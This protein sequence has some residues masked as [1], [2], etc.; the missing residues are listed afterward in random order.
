MATTDQPPS[1]ADSGAVGSGLAFA[2]EAP[3]KRTRK[4]LPSEVRSEWS[5]YTA[6]LTHYT[7]TESAEKLAFVRE[8][9]ESLKPARV[10][11]DAGFDVTMYARDLPPDTTSNRSGAQWSP[12]LRNK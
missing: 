10:L 1:H 12:T 7:A 8:T 11:Q 2:K 6:A 9:L 5:Q 4:A 3:R